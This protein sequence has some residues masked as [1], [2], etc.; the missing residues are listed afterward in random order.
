[1]SRLCWWLVDVVSRA[2]EA[3]ERDAVRG[4][5]AECGEAGGA[6]LR[7]VLGLVLRRQAALWKDWRPWLALAGLVVPLGMLLSIVSRGTAGGS[8]VYVWLYANNWDRALLKDAGFW[9]VFAGSVTFVFARCLR[10][11]CWSW[12]AGFVIGFVSRRSVPACGVLFCL[13]LA[14]GEI[15]GAP[16]YF[17]HLLRDIHRTLPSDAN[18]PVFALAFYREMFPLIVQGGLVALPSLWGMRQG[19]GAGRFPAML[20][21]V[22]W[23]GALG[24]LTALMTET[25]GA[26]LLLTHWRPSTWPGWQIHLLQLVVYW[27]MAYLVATRAGRH[28]QGRA[29]PG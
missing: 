19:A 16:R 3:G 15:L 7:D 5:L 18:G 20:R 12:T 13:M 1:M 6:A 2:L 23:I 4:D 25:P 11:V 24:A 22:L 27:P 8:A 28:W 14:F 9:R 10:L 26:G 21:I 29:A 17:A